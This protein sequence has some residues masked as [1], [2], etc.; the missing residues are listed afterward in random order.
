MKPSEATG[1]WFLLIGETD[2]NH[3]VKDLGRGGS[4]V[5]TLPVLSAVDV[6]RSV[7]RLPESSE[8]RQKSTA[9]RGYV[10]HHGFVAVASVAVSIFRGVG[11]DRHVGVWS[12]RI[13]V[14]SCATVPST[15]APVPFT[16]ASEPQEVVFLHN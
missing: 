2:G 12:G 14:R 10:G 8:T 1:V 3:E 9:I 13:A 4:G 7:P 6:N 5:K 16:A 15:T 11:V